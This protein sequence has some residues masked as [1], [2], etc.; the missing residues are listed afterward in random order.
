MAGRFG[1][2]ESEAPPAPMNRL[3]LP[4]AIVWYGPAWRREGWKG[5]GDLYCGY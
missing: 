5:D 4:L 3:E 2:T 1:E